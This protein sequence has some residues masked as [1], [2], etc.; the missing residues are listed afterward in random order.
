MLN[1]AASSP[2]NLH[3]R[4]L[5][6]K[7][8]PSATNSS[9]SVTGRRSFYSSNKS[10]TS[11]DRGAT[12]FE[13]DSDHPH[14]IPRSSSLV[15]F[16]TEHSPSRDDHDRDP[17]TVLNIR[18]ASGGVYGSE[19]SCDR[20]PLGHQTYVSAAPDPEG[21]NSKSPAPSHKVCSRTFQ[22]GD[23]SQRH[24]RSLFQALAHL[25]CRGYDTRLL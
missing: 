21:R 5:Q 15:S 10:V 24:S 9:R 8:N 18:L 17:P 25:R 4:A 6:A 14:S 19:R 23:L 13:G 1:V 20:E 3:R 7:L 22:L 12:H 16:Q 11:E 2:L